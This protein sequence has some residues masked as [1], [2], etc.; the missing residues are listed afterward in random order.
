MQGRLV[1]AAVSVALL[2][3]SGA[4][5]ADPTGT[6]KSTTTFNNQSLEGTLKL[7]YDTEGPTL[8]GYY[9]DEQ[10]SQEI[11]AASYGNRNVNFS[12]TRDLNRQRFTIKFSG[13]LSGD[14][15]TGKAQFI[16]SGEAQTANWVAQRNVD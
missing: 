10:I 7:R 2:V 1:A 14:T 15:I 11:Y 16:F 9:F 8:T 6:W 4:L 3:A 13:V 5:A 12:V